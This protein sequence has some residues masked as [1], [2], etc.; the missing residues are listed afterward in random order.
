MKTVSD[1]SLVIA[2]RTGDPA[3]FASLI[4]RYASA[5]RAVAFHIVRNHHASEDIAQETFIA[6]YQRLASLRVPSLFG[7]WVLRIAR[8]QALR[9]ADRQCFDLPL[10]LAAD[11]PAPAEASSDTDWLLAQLVRLPEREQRLL[12]LRYFNGHSMQDIAKIT[13]SPVGTITK[14]MSRGYA[15]LR[16]RLIE[17]AEVL[18]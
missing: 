10:D 2:T 13:G 12:M 1:E 16:Q 17:S 15:R 11:L 8:H 14:Q 7:R 18:I 4:S 6:A 3:A 5:V 9:S